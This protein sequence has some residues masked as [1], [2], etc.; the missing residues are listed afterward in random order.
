MRD[1]NSCGR[2]SIT[3]EPLC[4]DCAPRAVT[5]P[6]STWFSK[7]LAMVRQ[8]MKDESNGNE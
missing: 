8:A 7:R 4:G 6:A 5:W 1:C 3:C 2:E